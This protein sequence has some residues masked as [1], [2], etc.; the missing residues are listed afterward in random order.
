[1][2][3]SERSF[4]ATPRRAAYL[5]V[6][7]LACTLLPGCVGLEQPAYVPEAKTQPTCQTQEQK[8]TAECKKQAEA[9]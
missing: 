3:T 9:K 8:N 7:I 2:S 5:A 4:S 6:T 1:M